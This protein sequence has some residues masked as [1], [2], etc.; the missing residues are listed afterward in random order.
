M[1]QMKIKNEFK[2][3]YHFRIFLLTLLDGR[4]RSFK[5]IDNTIKRNYHRKTYTPERVQIVLNKLVSFYCLTKTKHET[6]LEDR[7]KYSY[8]ITPVGRKRLEYYKQKV[9]QI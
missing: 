7:S 6:T 3:D 4:E 9:T 2:L 8:T 1:N 5:E